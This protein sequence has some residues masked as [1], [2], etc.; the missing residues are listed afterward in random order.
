MD[1]AVREKLDEYILDTLRYTKT[2][3][4]FCDEE[5]NWTTQRVIE[6]SKMTDIKAKAENTNQ[7]WGQKILSHLR[8]SSS[9]QELEKELGEVLKSTL[10]GLENLQLF[11]DAVEKLAVTSVHIFVEEN[12]NFMPIVMNSLSV[13][14][15]IS[16]AISVSP[17]LVHFKRDAEAFFQPDLSNVEVLIFQLEKYISVTQQICEKMK[18]GS[19]PNLNSNRGEESVQEVY[20]RVLQLTKIRMDESFRLTFLFGVKAQDFIKV[21]SECHSRMFQFLSDLEEA[22]VQL[23]KMKKGSNI[24]TVAG[25]SVGIAGGVLSI[26]GLALAPVTVGVSL[27]LTIAGFGI[28][29]TSGVNGIV[30]AIT[31]MAV[32]SQQEKNANNIF[33]SFM[34]DLQKIQ[35]CVEDVATRKPANAGS[36]AQDFVDDISVEKVVTAAGDFGL[37]SARA[38]RNIP[39]MAAVSEV[40]QL[41]KGTSLAISKSARAG[42]IGLNALFIGL[43]V[44][45]IC[46][47]SMS[48][49]KGS[50]SEV[51]QII[52]SRA[53]LWR[54]EVEAWEK[55]HNH[56][57]EGISGFNK[58]QEILQQPWHI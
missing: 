2:V 55:I 32:N 47:D 54:S 6:L 21:F 3:Q 53:A 46:K 19:S 37:Q 13:C 33:I 15:K 12:D 25:S 50:K 4:E 41:A 58:N 36:E 29:V 16:A 45:L 17:L 28:G 52:R 10:E 56:L 31:E 22:A 26:V 14:S 24:S 27:A 1:N 39:Q 23:D 11:L 51:G 9:K 40:G 35:D 42:L 18:K 38:V 20:E 8:K 49:A 7:T 44:F 48:L 57:F 34:E 30:T 5:T 43:D